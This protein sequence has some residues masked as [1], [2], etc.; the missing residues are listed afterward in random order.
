MSKPRIE[1]SMENN[2]KLV[3]N[4]SGTY[5]ERD[6]CN[7][8]NLDYDELIELHDVKN[9]MEKDMRELYDNTIGRYI[10]YCDEQQ[11][12][13]QNPDF[14]KFYDFMIS[15]NEKF[16]YVLYRINELENPVTKSDMD[17]N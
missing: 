17:N 6:E 2:L 3:P 14:S 12:L 4:K 11:I 7:E 13:S 1:E 10:N 16:R 8:E 5:R 15:N 9:K